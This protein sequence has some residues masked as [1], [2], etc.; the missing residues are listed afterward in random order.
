MIVA[1]A[2]SFLSSF[3]FRLNFFCLPCASQNATPDHNRRRRKHL[4]C[5]K[6]QSKKSKSTSVRAA[7]YHVTSDITIVF[8]KKYYVAPGQRTT[9]CRWFTTGRKGWSRR[10]VKSRRA[11]PEQPPLWAPSFLPLNGFHIL[12][13][14]PPLDLV[15]D[16]FRGDINLIKYFAG[17]CPPK[18]EGR[19]TG[20]LTWWLPWGPCPSSSSGRDIIP[21][22]TKKSAIQ[23]RHGIWISLTQALTSTRLIYFCKPSDTKIVITLNCGT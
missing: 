18:D 11:L 1:A 15:P 14:S 19:Q 7:P 3:L 4:L 23:H 22:F 20:R 16:C 5:T 17:F 9:R 13:N 6:K 12:R 2:P 10:E 21:D 8:L